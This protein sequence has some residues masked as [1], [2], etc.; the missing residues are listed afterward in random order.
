MS[1]TLQ[2]DNQ[3]G[4]SAWKIMVDNSIIETSSQF[5]KNIAIIEKFNHELYN[6]Y[7]DNSQ[8]EITYQGLQVGVETDT[9]LNMVALACIRLPDVLFVHNPESDMYDAFRGMGVAV[10]GYE[11]LYD[12]CAREL[13]VEKLKISQSQQV[14]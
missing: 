12:V 7:L 2:V 11:F 5:S 6:F 13:D 8:Q 1:V 14:A 9:F 3:G 10:C 4:N